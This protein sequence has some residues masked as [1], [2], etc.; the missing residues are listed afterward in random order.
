MKH[1]MSMRSFANPNRGPSHLPRNFR[2]SYEY[3][4]HYQ[5]EDS[6]V[7]LTGHIG[8]IPIMLTI[9]LNNDFQILNT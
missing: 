2:S 7:L 1:T 8:H 3:L 6:C 9:E 5:S 4:I